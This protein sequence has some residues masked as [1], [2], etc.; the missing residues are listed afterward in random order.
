MEQCFEG[1]L[2]SPFFPQ[3][4]CVYWEFWGKILFFREVPSL[5]IHLGKRVFKSVLTLLPRSMRSH[6]V[7]SSCRT[8]RW[9]RR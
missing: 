5:P 4:R 8:A 9:N 1:L 6:P 2:K 3:I 7:A